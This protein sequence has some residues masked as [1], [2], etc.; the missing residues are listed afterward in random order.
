M[1]GTETSVEAEFIV[2]SEMS[3]EQ[4]VFTLCTPSP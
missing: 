4:I 1:E 3:S 2:I